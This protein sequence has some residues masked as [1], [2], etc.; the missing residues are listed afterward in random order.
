MSHL[1]AKS[2]KDYAKK[3]FEQELFDKAVAQEIEKLKTKK[4]FWDRIFPY[5]I[6]IE[7]K[8]NG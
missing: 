1:D 3:K 4:S 7:R 8:K 6:K 2:I 5:T